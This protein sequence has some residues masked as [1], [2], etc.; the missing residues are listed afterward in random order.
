MRFHAGEFNKRITFLGQ[1]GE[2]QYDEE[3]YPIPSEP[4]KK[5]VWAKVIP[6]SGREFIEAKATQSENIYR[7]IIRYRKDLDTSMKI[8]FNDRTFEIVSILNDNEDNV[9][10][11]IV[12]SEVKQ[13][14]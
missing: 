11:T 1:G 2:E 9:T 5:S 12:A 8:T 7:F 4:I 3:G 13:G 10:L 6:V 14:G